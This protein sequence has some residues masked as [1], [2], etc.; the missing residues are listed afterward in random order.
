MGAC[1]CFHCRTLY[2]STSL[3]YL[4]YYLLYYMYLTA[5][6]TLKDF[7][8]K[9]LN[10]LYKQ[11]CC[12]WENW[13]NCCVR[14]YSVRWFVCFYFCFHFN[15]FQCSHTTF[16]FI[17][18]SERF[19]PSRISQQSSSGVAGQR[20]VPWSRD[21]QSL[22]QGHLENKGQRSLVIVKHPITKKTEPLSGFSWSSSRTAGQVKTVLMESGWN[23]CR[24]NLDLI[25]CPE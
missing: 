25:L 5:S 7:Y 1:T 24:K 9:V 10:N 19:S 4:L 6:V 14:I 18:V 23:A 21:T 2:I 11:N 15:C 17:A 16:R 8:I 20:S 3:H 12:Y 22:L 13:I